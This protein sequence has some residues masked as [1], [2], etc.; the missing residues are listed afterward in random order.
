MLKKNKLRY[1]EYYNM[2][3]I[4]D[5]LYQRSKN[6]NN[7]YKLVEII[8]SKQN[9]RLAYRNIKS[10]KGSKT[11][12]TDKLTIIDISDI[13]D[14]NLINTVRNKLDDYKPQSVRRVYIEKM[15]SDKKRP[16]GIPT[17]W[18]RIIQ[19]CILQVLEPICE[20]KF[21]NHSYGFRPN[22]S[23]HHALSRVVT[24]IN[25]SKHHY[26]VDMDIKGF[27]DNVNHGKLLKQIWALGIRDKCLI[28]IISKI[29][30][31]EIEG[32]GIPIKGTP[33]GGIIS[34]LLSNIVLNELDWW[35][36]NQWETFKTSKGYK[37][38]NAFHQYAKRYTNL[39]NGYIVR[40]ADDFK[41][42]CKTYDEAKRYYYSTKEFLKTRLNLDISI[43]KSKVVNLKKNSSSFLGFKIKVLPKGKTKYG[44][45]AKT[46]ISDKAIKKVKANLKRKIK[47]IQNRTVKK[48]V[49]NYNL[50]V[51]GVQNYYRFATNV[52]NNLT[53]VDYALLR[54]KK[55]RLTNRSKVIR[56]EE[57]PTNFQKLVKGIKRDSKILKIV[58]EPM[59][60]ITGVNHKNPMNFSQDICSYTAKGREKI[61][62][63]LKT[64]LMEKL[65]YVINNLSSKESIEYND[66]KISRYL[67]QY[68]KCHVL[69]IEIELYRVYCHRKIPLELGGTN[70]YSNLLI[71]DIDVH[72]IITE[73]HESVIR[74]LLKTLNLNVEQL[75]KINLLRKLAGKQKLTYKFT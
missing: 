64:T 35:V 8:G 66:N 28:S 31:S 17:I 29:L 27:F 18:D 26:C 3:R 13:S 16:L 41:I 7:F 59:L 21:H 67:A 47:R 54:T 75:E 74:N 23:T 11:P 46:D 69:G 50:A 72:N 1:N 34:P 70:K 6:G 25:I 19:Q 15:G 12:G 39:K 42:M 61:H 55:V 44:Y 37:N 56:F 36:S 51:I 10:N 73:T 14:E 9:I 65:S 24:L 20:A 45:I 22:R 71:V 2:Q 68:G 32:E 38:T 60:P 5:E 58:G 62:S 4:Y 30:K 57:T 43:E 49:I 40:Y 52:Y 53:E 63:N 33:Q 48:N